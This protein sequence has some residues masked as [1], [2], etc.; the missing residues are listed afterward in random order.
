MICR[1]VLHLKYHFILFTPEITI[2][3][4]KV[5]GVTVQFSTS[6]KD[7]EQVCV[8]KEQENKVVWQQI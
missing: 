5:G 7:C 3:R 2:K 8:A 1:F 6:N 4:S